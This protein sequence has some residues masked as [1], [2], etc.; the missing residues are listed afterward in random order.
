MAFCGKTGHRSTAEAYKNDKIIFMKELAV[1]LVKGEDLK[2]RIQSLCI[3]KDIDTA[4]VLSGVGCLYHA[5]IRL[6]DPSE[7]LES[8]R[9]YEII[10]LTGTISKGYAHIHIGL[11]DEKGNAIGGHL[12]EGCLVN[13]TCELVLGILEEY[14]S[15]RLFDETTG[16]NEIE[17]EKVR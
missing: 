17:F 10:S 12:C 1:R 16:Y 5:K 9:D 11:A 2:K 4:V 15:N 6:A 8:D 7:Y 3:E 13:T 14:K